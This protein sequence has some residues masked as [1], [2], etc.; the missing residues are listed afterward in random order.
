ML[1]GLY[2]I[3][4]DIIQKYDVYKVSAQHLEWVVREDITGDEKGEGDRKRKGGLGW[5]KGGTVYGGRVGRREAGRDEGEVN[6][7]RVPVSGIRGWAW[8][9]MMVRAGEWQCVTEMTARDDEWW[10]MTGIYLFIYINKCIYGETQ[11][12]KILFFNAAMLVQKLNKN[13]QYRPI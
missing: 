9:C 10:C 12:I 13:T 7:E 8:R 4:D 1:N 6:G 2:T 11:F 3:F 5:K